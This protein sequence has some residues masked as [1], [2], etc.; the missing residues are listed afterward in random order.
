MPSSPRKRVRRLITCV[1]TETSSELTGSSQTIKSGWTAIARATPIRWRC[2]PLNSRG[3]RLA[4]PG[5]GRRVIE[6]RE[7]SWA[8]RGASEPVDSQ[9]LSEDVPH[10][11]T[12]VQ[13]AKGILED[14][15]E[16]TTPSA[17]I[18]S[19]QLR[20]DLPL[21]ADRPRCHPLDADDRASYRCLASARL[22]D[23]RRRATASD[24][25]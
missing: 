24:R 5:R 10:G 15:L 17:K 25:E 6:A 23:E 4:K 18:R 19:R 16:L 13:A 8:A 22:P 21:E 12:R 14:H 1:W 2:T 7:L 11:L 20:Q 9:G 3:Y